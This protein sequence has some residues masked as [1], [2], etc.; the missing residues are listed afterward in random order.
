MKKAFYDSSLDTVIFNF[1][2]SPELE[3]FKEVAN[4]AIPLIKEH[5]CNKI[6]N[7]ITELEVNSIENQEWTQKEWFPEVEKAGLKYFAFLMAE[8]IFGQVS[9]EQ[10]NEKAEEEGRIKIEYFGNKAKAE[11]WLKSI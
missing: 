3:A 7:D 6:L 11:E 2:G 5:N 8:N 1:S 9:A 10:T 4:S